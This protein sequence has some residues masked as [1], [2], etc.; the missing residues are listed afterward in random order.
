MLFGIELSDDLDPTG[1]ATAV[2]ALVTVISVLLT[3]R[4]LKQTQDEIDLSRREVEEAHRPVLVPVVDATRQFTLPSGDTVTMTP[5]AVGNRLLIPV[6]NI[7][8]GPALN[9]SMTLEF[10][11][12]A[13]RVMRRGL[14]TMTTP[15]IGIGRVV[16]LELPLVGA[17]VSPFTLGLRYRD[18]ADKEWITGGRYAIGMSS[19]YEELTIYARPD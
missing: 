1:L 19:R 15:G 3:R 17:A 5:Q 14:H 16:F 9:I 10:P 6:E 4:A 7:G 2:L 8:S 12:E 13:N 11:S 18:V